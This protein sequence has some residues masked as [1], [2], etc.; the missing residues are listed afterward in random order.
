M[1]E[2][3]KCS[4]T[5]WLVATGLFLGITAASASAATPLSPPLNEKET[6]ADR[7]WLL[8][9]GLNVAAL[10]CQFSPFLMAAANYNALLRQ[11]SDEFTNAFNVMNTYFARTKK[12][13]RAGARA[14]DTY[15]T[16]ANQNFS[17]FDAQYTFCDA[18]ATIARQALAVPKGKFG[19]FSETGLPQLQA[20]LNGN[21]RLPALH[22]FVWVNVPKVPPCKGRRCG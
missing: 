11:H 10:Q 15:A 5:G 18:A 22:N 12:G 16:R 21:S 13:Q 19:A 9:A 17:T 1:A 20:S 4:G 8:R 2:A 14:F 6:V 3:G 7:V